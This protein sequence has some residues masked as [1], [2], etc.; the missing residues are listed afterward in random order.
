MKKD[1]IAGRLSRIALICML[2][3]VMPLLNSCKKESA[4]TEDLL[5]TV[6]SSAGVVVGVNVKSLLEKIGCK[7]DGMEITPG[8]EVSAWFESKKGDKAGLHDDLQIFMDGESGINPNAAVLF[9]DSYNY[10]LT[11]M[12]A[13]TQKF[14]KFVEAKSGSKFEEAD[15]GVQV[16]GN[17]A[18][19][20]AQAWVC[21]SSNNTID[22]KAI[23]NYASLSEPRSFKSNSFAPNIATMTADMVVWGDIK[24]IG[25]YNPQFQQALSMGMMTGLTFENPASVAMT[26]DFLKGKAVLSSKILNDKSEPAKALL[27]MPKIDVETVKGLGT[28]ADAIFAMSI[29]KDVTKK[30]EK[31]VSSFG[32]MANQIMEILKPLDGTVAVAAGGDGDLGSTLEGV[33]TTD[34]EPSRDFM[35]MLSQFGTTR[36][37]GKFV[38]FSKGAVSGGLDIAKV[39][40]SFKGASVG[41]ALNMKAREIMGEN[42]VMNA[43]YLSG[44]PDGKSVDLE[45]TLETSDPSRNSLLTLLEMDAKK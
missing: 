30:V 38:R 34:G 25:D 27:P 13:D 31:A 22:A 41:F 11:V 5:S 2:A 17:V 16:C 9:M 26:V 14:M 21:V 23:A 12:I 42:S 35:T 8:K 10:Y 29:T 1:L 39:A 18:V 32:G 6:P 40:D 3:L 15:K 36:I 33:V 20:D 4:S 44:K 7:V 28:N 19:K 24:S 45:V 43:L 37:D